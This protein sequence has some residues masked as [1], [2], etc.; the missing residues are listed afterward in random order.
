MKSPSRPKAPLRDRNN[1]IMILKDQSYLKQKEVNER[2]QIRV[3][4]ARER[5][6]EVARVV[7]QRTEREK[8]RLVSE[9]FSNYDAVITNYQLKEGI[10][11]TSKYLELYWYCN[12]STQTE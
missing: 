11:Y 2:R 8:I 6:N 1:R 12:F 4:Q 5:A 9:N 10:A 3:K 7:R